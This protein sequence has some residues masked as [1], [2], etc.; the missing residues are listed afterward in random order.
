M[1]SFF[2]LKSAKQPTLLKKYLS[3][4]QSIYE[5][6]QILTVGNKFEDF[7][8]GQLFK[9]YLQ[10]IIQYTY[11]FK[12]LLGQNKI[13][14]LIDFVI[15]KILCKKS[16][17]IMHGRKICDREKNIIWLKNLFRRY[18]YFYKKLKRSLVTILGS[19]LEI[20]KCKVK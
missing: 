15:F 10:Y 5:N 13:Y 16:L 6:R 8:K 18:L 7:W 19:P 4:F 2:I 1:L 14:F 9:I 3:N 20:L 11:G 12:K 17:K